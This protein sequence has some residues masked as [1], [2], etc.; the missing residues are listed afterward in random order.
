MDAGVNPRSLKG[1]NIAVFTATN[2][3]EIEK[4]VFHHKVQVRNN[5]GE[6]LNNVLITML[7][8]LIS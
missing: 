8:K 4:N 1:A 6:V 2:I 3:S 5:Y 7:T